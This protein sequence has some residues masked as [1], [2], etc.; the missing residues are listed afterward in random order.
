LIKVDK[1][2]LAPNPV[3]YRHSVL[4]TDIED[5]LKELFQEIAKKK[6]FE[7]VMVEVG[8]RDHVHVF[9]SAHPKVAPSYIVKML[10]G[11]SARK[12]FLKFP[13]LKEKMVGGHLWNSS[14]FIETIG[15]VSEQAIK[16]YIDN[17]KKGDG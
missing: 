16:E 6:E 11:I 17:Q 13:Q 3:K 10:K 15:S 14:F 1:S 5:Y 2:P 9:A 7:V 8:E 12:L 4:L